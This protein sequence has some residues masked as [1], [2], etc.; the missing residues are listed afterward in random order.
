MGG[1]RSNSFSTLRR[2]G[3]FQRRAVVAF[4]QGFLVQG[5]DMLDGDFDA[6]DGAEDAAAD[7]SRRLANL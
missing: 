5:V 3:T 2:G 7:S 4:Q 6:V 1:L